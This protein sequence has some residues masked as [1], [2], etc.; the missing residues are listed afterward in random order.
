MDEEVLSEEQRHVKRASAARKEF[1]Q[2]SVAR[3]RAI[4]PPAAPAA[5][6]GGH[7]RGRGSG[8]RG[9]SRGRGSVAPQLPATIEQTMARL[10]CPQG[11]HIWRGLTR[12]EWCGHYPPFR[13]IHSKWS[14]LGEE[15]SMKDIL[16]RLWRMH[17]EHTGLDFPGCC[18]HWS[19][20]AEPSEPSA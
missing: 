20:L 1:V 8:G 12:G 18:P 14:A 15:G 7:G 5:A 3:R 16:R 19:L 17:A 10:F 4:S 6:A 2:A 13:R 11:G 9:R